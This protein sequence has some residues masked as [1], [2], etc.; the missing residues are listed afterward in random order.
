MQMSVL[1]E[2]S[3][4]AV[5]SYYLQTLEAS[6]KVEDELIMGSKR[7]EMRQMLGC[8]CVSL[9]SIVKLA[10]HISEPLDIIVWVEFQ[11]RIF[12]STGNS[13]SISI[14]DFNWLLIYLRY[15][16]VRFDARQIS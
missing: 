7:K 6:S 10:H 11:M 1:R 2:I 3:P 14:P 5:R 12:I 13:Q 15:F 8:E 16:G 9:P 4:V